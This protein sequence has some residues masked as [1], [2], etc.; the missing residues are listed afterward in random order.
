M[1]PQTPATGPDVVRDQVL[2][3]HAL[4]QHALLR[5][6]I[7]K[8]AYEAARV[9]S[10]ESPALS[11][12][13]RAFDALARDLRAHLVYEDGALAPILR[14]TD[15]WGVIRATHLRDDHQ[16]QRTSLAAMGEDLVSGAKPSSQLL[17]EITWFLDGLARDMETE[18]EQYLRAEVLSRPDEADE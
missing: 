4:A 16:A 7:A 3:Q 12:L 18:E 17:D 5:D 13:R 10:A 11:D 1:C 6:A 15:A 9:A 14:A 2:A 8:V